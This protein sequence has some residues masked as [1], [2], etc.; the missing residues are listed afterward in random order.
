MNKITELRREPVMACICGCYT[1]Y[2]ITK[3]EI[4]KMA[5]VII[6]FECVDCERRIETDIELGGANE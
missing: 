1:W 2:L 3:P 5:K 4:D 6:C